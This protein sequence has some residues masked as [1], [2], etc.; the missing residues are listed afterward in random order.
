MLIRKASIQELKEK[1]TYDLLAKSIYKA[2][3]NKINRLLDI[4]NKGDSHIYVAEEGG[5]RL[6]ILA[7]ITNDRNRFEI[8]SLFVEEKKRKEGIGRELVN[9]IVSDNNDPVIVAETDI[10]AVGFYHSLGFKI[11][12]LSE[13]YHDI[14]RFNCVYD[15]RDWRPYPYVDIIRELLA[16]DIR[17]WVSGGIAIDLYVGHKTREHCD[18]DI[19]IFRKDQGKMREVLKEWEIYHTHAP[20]LRYWRDGN[21]LESIPNIWLRR[22]KASPWAFEVIFEESIADRWIYRRN[23]VIQRGIEEIIFTTND[24]IPYL[25]PE[26]QLLYNGGGSSF[27]M[28]KNLDDLRSVLPLLSDV[29]IE[30]LVD[31]L[32]TSFPK[33][34]EWINMLENRRFE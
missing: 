24:G 31:S 26:I 16:A 13:I 5:Q 27:R 22:D 29:D 9:R 18:V 20:G 10:D 21:F 34:H 32:R 14:K 1:P 15:H 25:R 28:E 23:P 12:S 33:G 6:G 7:V 4:L 30:W 17:C 11:N 8:Q 3:T 2:T 19:S